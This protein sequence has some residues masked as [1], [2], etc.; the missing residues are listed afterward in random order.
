MNYECPFCKEIQERTSNPLKQNRI[1]Y[2]TEHFVVFPTIGCL[3]E[4]YIMI[5]SKKHLVSTCYIDDGLK[6]EFVGLIDKFRY[7]LQEKYGFYPIIFEHGASENDTNKGGCCILHTH[8]HIVPHKLNNSTEMIN[9][10]DLKKIGGY[11]DFFTIAYDKPYLFFMNND[12]EM[13]LRV[14]SDSVFPSQI[15][16]RWI[17]KDLNIAEKWDWRQ[18]PF[19]ENIHKT[20]NNME[21]L[22]KKIGTME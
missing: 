6:K 18:N 10:L 9:T 15:I 5:V 19:Y 11:N 2:E 1:I 21:T 17:A 13:F 12:N 4:N 22:I 7:L 3:T 16:R 14:L 8:L 20:I